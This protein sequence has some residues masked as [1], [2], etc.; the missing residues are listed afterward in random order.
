[1]YTLGDRTGNSQAAFDALK[2]D[3]FLNL[4]CLTVAVVTAQDTSTSSVTVK[5]IINERTVNGK[6]KVKY[7][8]FPAISDVPFCGDTMPNIGDPVLIGFTD[9]DFSNWWTGKSTNFNNG[10]PKT[11]NPESTE[12][13]G[14]NNAVVIAAIHERGEYKTSAEYN[15][16]SIT[17]STTDDGTGVSPAL[18]TFL[19]NWEGKSNTAYKGEDYWNY[20]IGYGHV[21]TGN[22]GLSSSSVLTDDECTALLKSDLTSYISSVNSQFHGLTLTQN[23][24]DALVSLCFN[25]GAYCWTKVCPALTADVKSGAAAAKMTQDFSNLAHVGG[26]VSSGLLRRRKAEAV[27]YNTGVYQNND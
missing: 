16:T 4:H 2:S 13:H 26:S 25:L 5:P 11:V 21:I 22:D 9:S 14:I 24:K 6:G 1:V 23:K 3:I 15:S 20:T 18:I 10:S 8:D 27:M 7:V 17:D 12:Q 19:E